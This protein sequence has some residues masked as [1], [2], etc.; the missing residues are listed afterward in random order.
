[1]KHYQS[2]ATLI[3]ALV[4]LAVATLLGAAGMRGTNLEMKMIASA[5]DRAMAFEAAE[6][7]L[8]AIELRLINSPPALSEIS[9][10]FT[11]EC[12]NG[13]CFD[14]EYDPTD[15]YR[16]C[17]IFKEDDLEVAEFWTNPNNYMT[18][19]DVKVTADSRGVD[20]E[21]K[22]VNTQYLVEFR[23]FIPKE[24]GLTSIIDDKEVGDDELIYMPLYRITAIA[25]GLG[26]RSEVMTQ[27]MVKVDLQ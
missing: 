13:N 9:T 1:M 18:M 25:K 4:L 6:S 22:T 14:G 7:T 8:R 26:D 27:A 12:A 17:R 20:D 24:R 16:T 21:A 2:G 3:V 5:R 15:P 10:K 19:A 11:S 23:C